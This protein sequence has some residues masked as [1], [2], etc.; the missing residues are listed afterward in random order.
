M[1]RNKAK[2]SNLGSDQ[3]ETSNAGRVDE[4][5][6]GRLHVQLSCRWPAV[7]RGSLRDSLL[8]LGSGPEI[9]DEHFQRRR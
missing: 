6:L 9:E 4:G 5:A 8:G 3:R 2:R 7:S 1:N